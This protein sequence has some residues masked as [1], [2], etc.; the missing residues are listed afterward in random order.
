[1]FENI[2]SPIELNSRTIPIFMALLA[3]RMVASNFLG[4]SNSRT[5]MF[6]LVVLFSEISFKSVTE[7]PKNA[8]SAPEIKAEQ[9]SI[10]IKTITLRTN[11]PAIP[12]T[13]GSKL[14]GSGSNSY[15]LCLNSQN[16]KSSSSSCGSLTACGAI[17][18]EAVLDA[19][20]DS[21]P[22]SG[23]WPDCSLLVK[24]VKSCT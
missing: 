12:V 10:R 2:V 4:R 3:I 9:Q 6:P 17:V 21:I 1:M 8:T 19:G 7:R 13:S 24:K 15:K 18:L 5:T 20:Y 22:W 11:V 14:R 23:F 16:G